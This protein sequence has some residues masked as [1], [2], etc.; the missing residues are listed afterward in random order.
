MSA[1]PRPPDGAR[2]TERRRT[3]VLVAVQERHVAVTV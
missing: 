1:A 2:M 3:R